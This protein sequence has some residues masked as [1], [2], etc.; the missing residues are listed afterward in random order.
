MNLGNP[1]ETLAGLPVHDY[2]PADGI[3]NPAG[4]AFRIVPVQIYSLRLDLVQVLA[5]FVKD[6][7]AAEVSGLVVAGWGTLGEEG[8]DVARFVEALVKART[9]L[10]GLRA[11]F[12]G[13]DTNA[14]GASYNTMLGDLAALPAAFPDLRHLRLRGCRGLRLGERLRH[15]GL[16]SLTLESCALEADVLEDLT[17]ASLPNLEHLELW[18]G[19]DRLEAAEVDQFQPLLQ[20]RR[21][22]RLRY[23][24]VRNSRQADDVARL[25]GEAALPPNLTTLD[26]SLGNLSEEGASALLYSDWINRLETI[27]LR[28]HFL[29]DNLMWRF[30]RLK[31]YAD[32]RWPQD[33]HANYAQRNNVV[34]PF[35]DA[36]TFGPEDHGANPVREPQLTGDE[37]DDWNVRRMTH[38]D[39]F[40][41]WRSARWR[42]DADAET[43]PLPSGDE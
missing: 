35:V 14:E 5:A 32:L 37:A 42:R 17:S 18:H 26:L 19:S 1:V 36:G 21:F 12:L 27:D 40:R 3:D 39:G 34:G 10:T 33:P 23:L 4:R 15:D 24:G 25:V 28:H 2:N 43:S 16:R 8:Q 31:P 30:E 13:E 41:R 20:A 22:P 6:P 29:P 9:Q 11:L 7:A 38:L